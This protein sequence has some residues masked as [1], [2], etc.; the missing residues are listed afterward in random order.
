VPVTGTQKDIDAIL[1][2]CRKGIDRQKKFAQIEAA[3]IDIANFEAQIFATGSEIEKNDRIYA[4]KT[5][6][7]A[8]GR[9]GEYHGMTKEQENMRVQQ[10]G[11]VEEMRKSVVMLTHRLNELRVEVGDEEIQQQAAE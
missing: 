7:Q 5:V 2:K 1:D 8:A 9:K 3:L 10:A 6:D 4:A 11:R